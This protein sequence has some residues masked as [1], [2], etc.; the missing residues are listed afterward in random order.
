MVRNARGFTLLE[1]IT[2]LFITSV[3]SACVIGFANKKL[4]D[5]T[6]MRTIEQ[7][8][9]MIKT[10]Q[11]MAMEKR[12]YIY[13]SADYNSYF[14]VHQGFLLDPIL[15][16]QLPEGMEV[17]ITTSNK[18]ITFNPDGEISQAG[19]VRFKVND[20]HYIYSINLGKGRFIKI[21]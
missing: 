20:D 21:E 4:A 11:T 1:V 15:T 18:K 13:C 6:Y 5:I 19:K 9:L 2:V 10:A 3:L 7:I 14:K 16:Q 17:L 8:Q 12:E